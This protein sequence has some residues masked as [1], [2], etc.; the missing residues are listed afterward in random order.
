MRK[1]TLHTYKGEKIRNDKGIKSSNSIVYSELNTFE[2]QL[3]SGHYGIK[4]PI[5]GEETYVVNGKKHNI[6]E[7]HYLLTN[8]GMKTEVTVNSNELVKGLCIGFTEDFLKNLY[9]NIN[10]DLKDAL[11]LKEEEFTYFTLVSHNYAIKNSQLACFLEAL[12]SNLICNQLNQDYSE[13]QFFLDLGELLINDQLELRS[14]IN[15][16]NQSKFSTQEEIYKRIDLMNQYIHD[17]YQSNISLEELAK[18]ACLS[19]YH[20]VRCYQKIEGISPY[21][22]IINLRLNKAEHLLLKGYSINEISDSCGFADYRAFSKLFKKTYHSTP[23]QYKQNIA[24]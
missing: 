3:Y 1:L 12:K 6:I 13:E 4:L 5:K 11:E 18:I 2:T 21:Q 16:L 23:S 14:K 9:T 7:G 17:N 10:S 20:A 19:K 15:N 22:K 8:P 24:Q